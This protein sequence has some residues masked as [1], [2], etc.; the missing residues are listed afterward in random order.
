MLT[1]EN[2]EVR[3]A[4]EVSGK[5]VPSEASKTAVVESALKEMEALTV[6]VAAIDAAASYAEW[7][8]VSSWRTTEGETLKAPVQI[9][10]PEAS[11]AELTPA[12]K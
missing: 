7:Q 9:V 4:L 5:G 12:E 6:E 3:Q 10:D 1:A 11:Y 2:A 8:D